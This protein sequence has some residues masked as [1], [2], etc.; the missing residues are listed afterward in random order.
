MKFVDPTGTLTDDYYSL[1]NGKYLGSDAYGTSARL[2][3]PE[4]YRTITG[5]NVM[6][7]NLSSIEALRDNSTAIF[8]D[9]NQI[10][11]HA[12]N[13]A[14]LSR[15]SQLEYQAILVLDRENATITSVAGPIGTNSNAEIPYYPAPLTGV[16]FYDRPGGLIIIGEVHGHPASK[17]AGMSTE[18]T[19]SPGFDV[20]LAIRMQIP[21]YG[22]DAM[23]GK[24]GDSM[25]VHMVT[26]N[27]TVINNVRKTRG[28]NYYGNYSNWGL[29]ALKYWG[30]SSYPQ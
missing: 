5:N 27:G 21:I 3:D 13:V 1:T 4:L 16:S 15:A 24:R 11:E 23:Y 30:K 18:H 22:I 7:K 19:M 20:P 25:P 14:D 17:E 26:P 9:W 28:D 6:T 8:V 12:Q 10:E 2:I 29:E